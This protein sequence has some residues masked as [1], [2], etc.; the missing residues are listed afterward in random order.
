[1]TETTQEQR[2]L[3]FSGIEQWHKETD[4]KRGGL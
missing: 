4:G 3:L 1:M 2:Q